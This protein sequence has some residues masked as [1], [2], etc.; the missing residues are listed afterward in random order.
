MAANNINQISTANT[1]EHWLIATQGLITT[2][3]L[4]T[5][6]NGSTF[7]ANTKLQIGGVGSSLNVVTSGFIETLYSNTI[8]SN[9]VNSNVAIANSYIQFG[10]GTRQYTANA[11]STTSQAAFDQANSANV[12]AQAAFDKANTDN[13]YVSVTAGTYGNASIVS[14]VVV[15]ANG[16]ITS[17]QN[18]TIAIS[19]TAVT[20]VHTFA[21]GGTNAASYTT[22]ALLTS[23]GTAIVS[24]ANTGT[25]GTY[26]NAA[27]V[28]VITTDAYGRVSSVTNTA[29]SIS[30][31]SGNLTV[32]GELILANDY[33]EGVVSIGNSDSSKTLSL[34][35]GTFQTVTMNTN[36]TFTMPSLVAGKSFTLRTIQDSTGGWTAVFTG[37]I[38]PSGSAP[39]ITT[40]AS[41]G[42]DLI[43]FFC[44]GTYWYGSTIQNFS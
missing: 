1:F 21:Q 43:G 27:Y 24:L 42:R 30:S 33:I 44:D 6:G 3:N 38:W 39:T 34:S 2:A 10:D 8:N 25:A 31:V 4:L 40:T 28:P 22:G 35:S 37:V 20:G 16:R 14:A 36:C 7:Y 32:N 9:V 23:N 11:K 17:I 12:L 29:I 19:A 18:T 13:T 26:G 41:T 5:N 15:A